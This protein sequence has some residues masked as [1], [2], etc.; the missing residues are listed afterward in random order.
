M[1]ALLMTTKEN[2]LTDYCVMHMNAN[3]LSKLLYYLLSSWC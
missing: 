1:T 3:E 2:G